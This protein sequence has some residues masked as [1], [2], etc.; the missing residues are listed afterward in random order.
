LSATRSPEAG[1]LRRAENGDDFYCNGVSVYGAEE[2][3]F[4]GRARRRHGIETF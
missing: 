3:G 4:S 2:A 1:Q